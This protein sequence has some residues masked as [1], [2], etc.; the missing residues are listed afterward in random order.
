MKC[1]CNMTQD[2]NGTGWN[3]CWIAVTTLW[4]VQTIGYWSKECLDTVLVYCLSRL[5]SPANM[6]TK[7]SNQI[8]RNEKDK[9]L[10]KGWQWLQNYFCLHFILSWEKDSYDHLPPPQFFFHSYNPTTRF[11]TML[12]DD[13]R[14]LHSTTCSSLLPTLLSVQLIKYYAVLPSITISLVSQIL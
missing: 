10:K 4:Y 8:Q 7:T 6:K 11:W 13:L 5:E 1:K 14:L 12:Y 2:N 3:Q 9:A